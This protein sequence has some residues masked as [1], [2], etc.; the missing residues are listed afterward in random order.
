MEAMLG[1][2]QW[3][4]HSHNGNTIVHGNA[5]TRPQRRARPWRSERVLIHPRGSGDQCVGQLRAAQWRL[6]LRSRCTG[7]ECVG[8]GP[9]LAAAPVE[10]ERGREQY[11]VSDV[12]A[13][14]RHG[15]RALELGQSALR[16]VE[17]ATV[18]VWGEVGWEAQR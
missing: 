2:P 5:R 6:L 15:T 16:G 11:G 8:A 17:D 10:L 4:T 18:E 9:I 12:E 14:G 13:V 3:H 7:L 1:E